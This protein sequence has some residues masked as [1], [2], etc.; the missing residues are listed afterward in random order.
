MQRIGAKENFIT[1]VEYLRANDP[2]GWNAVK[3]TLNS[4]STG[5]GLLPQIVAMGDE[6]WDE[7]INDWKSSSPCS[8]ALVVAR[9]VLREL[10]W[11]RVQEWA[12]EV[13]KIEEQQARIIVGLHWCRTIHASVDDDREKKCA[14]FLRWIERIWKCP[15]DRKAWKRLHDE[16]ERAEIV[17][18]VDSVQEDK[19]FVAWRTFT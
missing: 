10:P 11:T 1:A 13:R 2:E 7:F 12:A 18:L 17:W 4:L 8:P 3:A 15:A 16:L 6:R 5:E 19:R 9:K 14:E